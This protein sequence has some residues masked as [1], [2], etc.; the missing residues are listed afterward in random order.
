MRIV[1]IG[2]LLLNLNLIAQVPT[3]KQP[4]TKPIKATTQKQKTTTPSK[5][6][7][8]VVVKKKQSVEKPAPVFIISPENHEKISSSKQPVLVDVYAPWCGPCIKMGPLFE[9]AARKFSKT[10]R[11][12][13]IMIESFEESDPTVIFLKKTYK[14]TLDCVPTLLF[15]KNGKVVEKIE[16]VMSLEAL[17]SKLNQL[18]KQP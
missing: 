9:Q 5:T 6:P 11:F 3:Q 18:L 17:S 16:G 15:I 2:V 1:F 4:S 14:I 10:I 12:A 8:K 7:T 13:K